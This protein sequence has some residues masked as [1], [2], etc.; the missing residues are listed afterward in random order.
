I[1]YSLRLLAQLPCGECELALVVLDCLR[2]ER[3]AQ[4]LIDE[5]LHAQVIALKVERVLLY[6]RVGQKLLEQAEG[7][8]R[9]VRDIVVAQEI[10]AH[11]HGLSVQNT[12][13]HLVPGGITRVAELSGRT[14]ETDCVGR[15]AAREQ[16]AA[17]ERIV[18]VIPLADEAPGRGCVVR[19]RRSAREMPARGVV[20][21]NGIHVGR[22]LL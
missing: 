11:L 17:A 2:V 7:R 21:F 3:H 14:G 10:P 1:I 22:A 12:A 8:T 13:Y 16:V 6:A 5:P 15:P 19:Q 9:R 18:A 20:S 4:I